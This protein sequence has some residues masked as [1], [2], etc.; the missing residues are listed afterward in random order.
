[1]C[2]RV[3]GRHLQEDRSS[4]ACSGERCRARTG[5]GRS[6]WEGCACSRAPRY[7]RATCPRVSGTTSAFRRTAA[8]FRPLPSRSS[9]LSH[10]RCGASG[11]SRASANSTQVKV[12][13]RRNRPRQFQDELGRRGSGFIP[14]RPGLDRTP[15]EARCA[16]DS[17][18]PRGS[19][20]RVPGIP[21]ELL[22]WNPRQ[23]RR[24]GEPG[25]KCSRSMTHSPVLAAF[26]KS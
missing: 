24:R 20:G 2:A 6:P 19:G 13:R 12:S 17:G 15:V 4:A 23:L 18:H 5:C 25:G 21:S 26:E 9:E 11:T 1:M 22:D 3:E 10:P 7:C 14:R 16:N 8:L